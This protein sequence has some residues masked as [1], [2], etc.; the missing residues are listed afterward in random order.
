MQYV[1][2]NHICLILL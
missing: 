1:L 2:L